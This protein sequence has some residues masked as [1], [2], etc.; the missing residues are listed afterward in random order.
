MKQPSIPALRTWYEHE[1]RVLE[2]VCHALAELRQGQPLPE[3]EPGLNRKLH[4]CMRRVN[5]RLSRQG[6]GVPC[7]PV[8][9]G[10]NQPLVDDE[11]RAVREDKRPDFQCGFVNLQES[12]DDR[13]SMFY[14]IE[15]KRLGRA[16]DRWVFNVNYV[17]KGVLRF[18]IEDYGYGKATP[19]GAMVGYVQSMEFAQILADVN[20]AASKRSL[21]PI[22]LE[23]DAWSEDGVSRLSHRLTRPASLLSPFRLRHLW[24][25]V[26]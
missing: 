15:C 20:G 22:V 8:W 6:R 14:T 1:R 21:P 17:D 9:E 24:V 3:D 10:Q 23:D 18:V 12:D 7:A 25:D 2:I 11:T 26:R 5:T 16:A 4:F 19:S 13:A